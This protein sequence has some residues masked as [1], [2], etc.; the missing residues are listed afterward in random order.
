MRISVVG[1]TGRVGAKLTR[2]L[3]SAGHQVR[4]LSRG[5]PTLDALATV[6]AEPFLGGFDTGAGDLDQF[7]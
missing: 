7:F 5:G 1:A 2:A 3:L 6:G 4:A